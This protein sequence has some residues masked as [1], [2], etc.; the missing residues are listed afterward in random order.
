MT[1]FGDLN[2]LAIFLAIASYFILGGIWFPLTVK[3]AY[4]RALD[5]EMSSGIVSL[6]VP[7]A[8][9]TMTTI[10]CAILIRLL[11]ITSYTGEIGFGLLVGIGY[12]TPMVV[13][14]R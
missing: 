13:T 8:C 6:I 4:R 14:S 5:H 10:T 11:G 9:I 3:N 2:L 7:L 1:V 12:L